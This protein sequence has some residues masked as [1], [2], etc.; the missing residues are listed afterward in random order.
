MATEP[1]RIMK[2]G[3]IEIEDRVLC[4]IGTDYLHALLSLHAEGFMRQSHPDGSTRSTGACRMGGSI[5]IHTDPASIRTLVEYSP[6][7]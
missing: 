3:R 1:D 7:S 6:T 5:V 4:R 2:L